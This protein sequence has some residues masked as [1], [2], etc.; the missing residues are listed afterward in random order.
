MHTEGQE[1]ALAEACARGDDAAIRDLEARYFPPVERALA[2]MG[3]AQHDVE[4]TMQVLRN[5]LFV[6]ADKQPKIA[7]FSGR[8]DLGGWLRVTATRLAWKLKKKHGREIPVEDVAPLKVELGVTGGELAWM[9]A[10]YRESFAASFREA[11][12]ELDAKTKLLLKQHL[13]DGL[14]IDD[15]ANLHDVHRATAARW[16]VK[17]KDDLLT[18]ARARF[19]ERAGLSKKDTDSVL[20]MVQS[21]LDVTLRALAKT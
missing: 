10:S 6:A 2:K 14:T 13:L 3:L 7:E 21:K 4:E 5:Q 8:G 1:L 16:I 19:A 18:S 15:L 9:K 17:A 11:L 20:R 12:A